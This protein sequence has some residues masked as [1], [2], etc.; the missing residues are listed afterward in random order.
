MKN[1]QNKILRNFIIA[2][3]VL[4]IVSIMIVAWVC[5]DNSNW[6]SYLGSFLGG[7]LGGFAT[8]VAIYFTLVSMK[9]DVMPHI[10]PMRTVLYGYYGKNKGTFLSTECLAEDIP[11]I[12]DEHIDNHKIDFNAFAP[13]FMKFTN[14]GKDSALNVR[15]E[16]DSPSESELYKILLDYGI[17]QSYFDEH[18]DTN[19]KTV[20]YSD[21]MQPVK[22]DPDGYRVQITEELVDLFR[23]IMCVFMGSLDEYATNES[24]K[25]TFG[26]NFVKKKQVFTKVKISFED[27]NGNKNET[28]FPIYCRIQRHIGTYNDGYHRM[29]I[30]LSTCDIIN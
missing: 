29:Q 10:I 18:F 12:G 1:K 4:C 2:Y 27:L 26:N 9:Q 5:A 17:P 19:K 25:S 7:I 24:V 6:M 16:W 3:L 15:V 8:L 30:E 13:T 23:Y 28:E 22:I 20:L 14:I 11:Q 21:Y